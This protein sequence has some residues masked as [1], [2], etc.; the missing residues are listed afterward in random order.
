MDWAATLSRPPSAATQEQVPDR[1]PATITFQV[2]AP[3]IPSAR[4]RWLNWTFFTA[5]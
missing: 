4:S 5:A 3:T 2:L 1:Y